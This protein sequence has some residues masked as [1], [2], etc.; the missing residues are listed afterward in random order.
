VRGFGLGRGV[1]DRSLT[2]VTI[3]VTLW[4]AFAVAE[5]VRERRTTPGDVAPPVAV[6]AV[7]D[8]YAFIAAGHRV[9]ADHAERTIVAFL[10]LQCPFSAAAVRSL[11][12]LL[13]RY[14]DK[15]AVVYRHL[16]MRE[17]S[18]AAATALECAAQDG[19]FL[20]MR[21]GLLRSAGSFFESPWISLAREAGVSDLAGFHACMQD[22]VTLAVVRRDAEAAQRLGALGTPTLLVNDRLYHG[23]PG[24][25]ELESAL[26]SWLSRDE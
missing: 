14:P 22:S 6:T 16:P 15:V 12:D 7:E 2:Y 8:P 24:A 10:D 23:H 5:S 18:I 9:G 1:L 13:E 25:A 11:S 19:A 4:A 17:W 3:A 20:A 21:D 26:D